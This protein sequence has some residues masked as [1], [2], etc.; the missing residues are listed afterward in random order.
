MICLGIFVI[1]TNAVMYTGHSSHRLFEIEELRASVD[2]PVYM[3][4]CI[5]EAVEA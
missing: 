4:H 2:D 1:E 5:L 3:M